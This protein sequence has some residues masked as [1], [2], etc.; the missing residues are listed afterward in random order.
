MLMEYTERPPHPD[1]AD[2]IRTYWWLR[3]D[4]DPAGAADPALPDGSPELIV[5][6]ADPWER[7]TADGAL[8]T[9]PPAFL[10]GQILRPMVV[11]PTGRIAL[12]A[13]RFEAHGAALVTDSIGALTDSWASLDTLRATSFRALPSALA[14]AEIDGTL[15]EAARAHRALSACV[16]RVA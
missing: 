16:R 12:V 11:R 4:A 2:I 5:N 8:L 14:V 3:G 10:V 13:V 15:T 7:V 6:L 9:Q 1:L